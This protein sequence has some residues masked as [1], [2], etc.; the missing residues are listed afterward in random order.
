VT[1]PYQSAIIGYFRD[2]FTAVLKKVH[3]G[4]DI[5]KL[6]SCIDDKF[7]FHDTTMRNKIMKHE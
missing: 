5:L 7:N 4:N 3:V 1:M 2:F 6:A